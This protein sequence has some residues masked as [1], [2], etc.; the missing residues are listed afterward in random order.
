MGS[1]PGSRERILQS[2]RSLFYE[3]GYQA[4]SVDDILKQC[5]VAKSNFYYHFRSKEELAFAVLEAQIADFEALV[6]RS[7]RNSAL[8]PS[9]RIARFFDQICQAQVKVQKMAG[10]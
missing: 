1:Q 2:A 7:L 4:T 8:T 6:T 3:V 9:E 10:C 5:G